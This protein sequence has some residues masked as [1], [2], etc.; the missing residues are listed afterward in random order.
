MKPEVR[1]ANEPERQD[2]TL[3]R[4]PEQRPGVWMADKEE[5]VA[6]FNE[7]VALMR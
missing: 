4:S 7:E 3:G 1:S 2:V 5:E 6:A